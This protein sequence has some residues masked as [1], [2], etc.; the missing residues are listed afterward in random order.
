MRIRA[1]SYIVGLALSGAMASSAFGTVIASDS[2][3]YSAGAAAG[4]SGGT[5][6]GANAY[7]GT[8]NITSPGLTFSGLQSSGNKVST[9]STSGSPNQ[10]IFRIL[11]ASQGGVANSSIF[12]S[13]LASSDATL[14][15]YA[16][17]SLFN[18]GTEELFIGKV[19][20]TNNW[21]V[22]QS[23]I[24]G[25][26]GIAATTTPAFLVAQIAYGANP[27]TP[28]VN[29]WVNPTP[30]GTL[31]TPNQTAT[32]DAIVFDRIRIQSGDQP[33]NFDEV[34]IGTTYPDVSPVP[35]P[36]A[37]GFLGCLALGML[38]RRHRRS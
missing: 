38:R 16:G 10:G 21:G 12:I 29:L 25:N 17:L 27:A 23:T 13:V 31:G 19:S 34:R 6:F 26:S 33:F 4:Q 32:A 18:G 7:T 37:A 36:A 5:G 14:P 30:G 2:F 15:N 3:S 24:A 28:T 35:E 11:S 8:A 20:S 1:F 22:A 9:T